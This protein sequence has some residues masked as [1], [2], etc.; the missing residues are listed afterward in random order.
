MGVG[1]TSLG[2]KLAKELG[3][4][5]VDSDKMIENKTGLKIPEIFDWQGESGFRDLEKN[6]V[7]ELKSLRSTVISVGGGLPCFGENM[8]NL[9]SFGT[10]IYL[11]LESKEIVKRLHQSKINRPLL[12]GLNENELE[13]YINEKLIERENFYKLAHFTIRPDRFFLENCMRLL[14]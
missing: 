3:W 1:K 10:T 4:G 5:F 8:K 7:E 11:K 6:C 2:K 14:I 9:N 13:I 12:N